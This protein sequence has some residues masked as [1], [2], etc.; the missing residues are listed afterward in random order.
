MFA[1]PTT[2]STHERNNTSKAGLTLLKDESI[3]GSNETDFRNVWEMRKFFIH[4]IHK[5]EPRLEGAVSMIHWQQRCN[6]R[7]IVYTSTN[8]TSDEVISNEG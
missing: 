3:T 6:D 2:I 7:N 5:V 4:I 1:P 8:P